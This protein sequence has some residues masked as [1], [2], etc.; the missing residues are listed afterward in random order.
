MH[1]RV[2]FVCLS[3]STRRTTVGHSCCFFVVR[4]SFSCTGVHGVQAETVFFMYTVIWLLVLLTVILTTNTMSRMDHSEAITFL[5]LPH[6]TLKSI[7]NVDGTTAI[8]QLVS[9]AMHD[10]QVSSAWKSNARFLTS[11]THTQRYTHSCLSV[12]LELN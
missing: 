1:L 12:L 2:F 4:A 9:T 11:H 8:S 10:V 5:S 7:P 6:V 3:C